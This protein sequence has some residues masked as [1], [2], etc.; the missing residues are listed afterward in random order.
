[1][2]QSQDQPHETARQKLKAFRTSRQLTVG[3]M[4]EQLGC[5][6]S[7][8]WSIFSGERKPGLEIAFQIEQL[9]G[10]SARAW[11]DDAAA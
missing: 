11:L 10:I 4:A 9:T 1:M 5:S 8:L 2:G 7:H 3:E 6:R